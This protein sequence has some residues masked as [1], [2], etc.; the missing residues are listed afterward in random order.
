MTVEGGRQPEPQGKGC[1]LG[2]REFDLP[3]CKE[4]LAEP[5]WR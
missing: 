2:G 5:P 4:A 1:E 3:G